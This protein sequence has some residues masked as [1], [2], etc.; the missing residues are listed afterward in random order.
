MSAVHVIPPCV[1]KIHFHNIH[2][3]MSWSPSG[4]FTFDFPTNN[5]YAF[6][7]VHSSYIPCLPHPHFLDHYN[8][9][10]RIV[11]VTKLLLCSILQFSVTSSM[12]GPNILLNTLFSNIPILFSSFYIRS[13]F[14]LI[15]EDR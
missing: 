3:P 15:Q 9:T 14:I 6:L 11:Q 2:P 10:W 5:L 8:Y 12:F 1:S 7:F 4:L 13:S